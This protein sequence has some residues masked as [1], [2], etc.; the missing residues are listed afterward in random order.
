MHS[1]LKL[2]KEIIGFGW[3]RYGGQIQIWGVTHFWKT[4]FLASWKIKCWKIPSQGIIHPCGCFLTQMEIA[5][6]FSLTFLLLF[7]FF[8]GWEF[9]WA[10]LSGWDPPWTFLLWF[11]SLPWLGNPVF[12]LIE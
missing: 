5:R 12:V 11:S 8:H 1:H 6:V 10:M 9:D 3:E 7:L 2:V 4:F